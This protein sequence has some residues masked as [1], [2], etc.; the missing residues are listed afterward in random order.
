MILIQITTKM[1]LIKLAEYWEWY[2]NE[3]KKELV[4][5]FAMFRLKCIFQKKQMKMFGGFE[6][7]KKN[8]LR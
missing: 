4:M 2:L 8:W 7:K 6:K 3:R 5:K 1:L